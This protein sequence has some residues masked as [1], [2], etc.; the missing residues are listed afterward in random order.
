MAPIVEHEIARTMERAIVAREKN[1][2]IAV[3][4]G[5]LS[6][7]SIHQARAAASMGFSP[8]QYRQY[9]RN[10]FSIMPPVHPNCRCTIVSIA[11]V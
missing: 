7:L 10:M 6:G 9:Q 2:R 5:R 1:L 8:E 4:V 3:A 11:S